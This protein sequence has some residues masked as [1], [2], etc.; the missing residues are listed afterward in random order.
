MLP[1]FPS[2]HLLPSFPFFSVSFLF[3]LSPSLP[4][5]F[6]FPNPHAVPAARG[7]GSPITVRS[8]VE[9]SSS[10]SGSVV[11]VRISI[12]WCISKWKSCLR[13]QL[14]W[15]VFGWIQV[16]KTCSGGPQ[17]C[18]ARPVTLRTLVL[19]EIVVCCSLPHCHPLLSVIEKL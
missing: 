14:F 10:P 11:R 6:P 13:W 17:E 8:S 4:Y 19:C 3:H 5:I 9:R 16:K 18:L 1:C 12:F 15:W 2:F 7:K